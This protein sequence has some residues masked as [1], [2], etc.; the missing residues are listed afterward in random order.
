[1]STEN[2]TS[3]PLEL[4]FMGEKISLKAN[5]GNRETEAAIL[6]AAQKLKEVEEKVPRAAPYKI[7]VLALLNLA[8]DMVRSQN[9]VVEHQEAFQRTAKELRDLI[10]EE[11]QTTK[12][13]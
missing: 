8:E 10:Q 13:S 9:K 12:N 4:E 3:P 6:I 1:M 2:E 5:A 11:C 7:A